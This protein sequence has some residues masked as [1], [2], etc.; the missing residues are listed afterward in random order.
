MVYGKACHLPIEVKH[1]AYGAIRKLN[2]DLQASGEKR[3]LQLNDLE[4]FINE[5][6]ENAKFYKEKAKAWPD[7][8]IVRKE[9]EPGQ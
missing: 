5:G 9:F 2:M 7:K 8:H 1:K 6:Y 3:L 4:E